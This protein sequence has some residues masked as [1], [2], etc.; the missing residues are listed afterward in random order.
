MYGHY[1]HEH[2]A[3]FELIVVT[4]RGDIR[5]RL[6]TYAEYECW[7]YILDI[8]EV[9]FFESSPFASQ[10]FHTYVHAVTVTVT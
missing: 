5:N 9:L 1:C 6:Y 8:P 10:I 2:G 7:V 3:C 4:Q